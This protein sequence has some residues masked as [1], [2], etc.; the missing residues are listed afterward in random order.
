M[1]APSPHQNPASSQ[2]R[3]RPPPLALSFPPLP[4]EC[5]RQPRAAPSGHRS[6]PARSAAW[7]AR[8]SPRRGRRVARSDGS[9][10]P[11]AAQD[12]P[13]GYLLGYQ[14]MSD[15]RG[16]TQQ[17]PFASLRE[18]VCLRDVEQSG[19]EGGL[20]ERAVEPA[21]R[22]SFTVAS[23]GNPDEDIHHG[24][25]VT[26]LDGSGKPAD[27][28]RDCPSRAARSVNKATAVGSAGTAGAIIPREAGPGGV[29]LAPQRARKCL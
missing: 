10:A 8:R 20:V 4:L 9:F 12:R 13:S 14:C 22:E 17:P 23:E 5:E 7:A 27:Q 3:A 1:Q 2:H 25:M 29:V 21:T 16:N 19:V 6:S 26:S 24:P 18:A 11:E 28:T 15:L